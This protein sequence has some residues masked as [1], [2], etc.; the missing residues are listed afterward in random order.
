MR[1]DEFE[2]QHRQKDEWAE[3]QRD[4]EKSNSNNKNIYIDISETEINPNH[5]HIQLTFC[6]SLFL[7]LSL[8]DSASFAS[9]ETY[10]LSF[11]V[12]AFIF[13]KFS[14]WTIDALTYINVRMPM[15]HQM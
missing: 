9:L 7:S 13:Y 10:R 3:E 1:I 12:P 14:H 2:E 8:C 11:C 5:T 6:V 15:G 4:R